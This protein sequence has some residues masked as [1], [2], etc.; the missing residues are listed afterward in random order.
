MRTPVLETERLLLRPFE[1]ADTRDVLECWGSD[2]D[3][4]KYMFWTSQENIAE[5]EEWISLELGQIDNDNWYRFAIVLKE[6]HELAG[7][8]L[9]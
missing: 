7:T 3:V 2:P 5:T 8:C 4:A 9:I 6:T 1:R